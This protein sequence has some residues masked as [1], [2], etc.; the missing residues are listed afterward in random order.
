MCSHN[1]Q[2]WLL[3]QRSF[4]ARSQSV[5]VAALPATLSRRDAGIN[6]IYS[7][8]ITKKGK[9]IAEILSCMAYSLRTVFTALFIKLDTPRPRVIQ[10]K[11]RWASPSLGFPLVPR[12]TP[13]TVRDQKPLDCTG[14]PYDIFWCLNLHIGQIYAPI[15]QSI[16]QKLSVIA[17]IPQ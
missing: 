8:F 16:R 9:C 15:H 2:G 11:L 3:H 14:C 17:Y 13:P 12:S 6:R 4:G 10:K 7:R 1:S 5:L